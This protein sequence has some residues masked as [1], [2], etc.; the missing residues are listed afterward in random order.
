[1]VVVGCRDGDKDK[2]HNLGASG[3]LSTEENLGWTGLGA[4]GG[5]YLGVLFAVCSW[6]EKEYL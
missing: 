5:K 3:S 6:E 1:M 4:V 2:M